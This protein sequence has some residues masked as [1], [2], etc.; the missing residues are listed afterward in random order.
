[1]SNLSDLLPAGA[2]AK[3][4]TATDSGSGITSGKPVILETA[5][6]VTQIAE[7][8]VSASIPEGSEST[9]YP[10]PASP[11]YT[12]AS[13]MDIAFDSNS[14]KFVITYA[15]GRNSSYFTYI[16]GEVNTGTGALTWGTRTVLNSFASSFMSVA[17]DPSTA[18]TLAVTYNVSGVFYVRVGTLS[19]TTLR[20]GTVASITSGNE[21]GQVAFD[22]TSGAFVVSYA[23]PAGSPA[24]SLYAI[25]GTYV[26]TTITLG[27][28]VQLYNLAIAAEYVAI[29][30]DPN[31]SGKFTTVTNASAAPYQGL[32]VC[33]TLS[34][35]TITEGT[36]QNYIATKATYPGVVYD[37]LTANRLIICF[38]DDDNS[39]Y[40]AAYAA[41][42]SGTVFTF[43]TK[44]QF[45]STAST[46][47]WPMAPAGVGGKFEVVYRNADTAQRPFTVALSLSGTTVTGGTPVQITTYGVNDR[48]Y[49][50]AAMNPNDAGS[51]V[52]SWRDRDYDACI[53][54]TSQ[55]GWVAT[56][57]TTSNFLGIADE[58]ISAS[59]SGVIVV[60]G[61]T[62]AK[63]TSLTIGSN[64]YV[65]NDGTITTVSST[66]SAGLAISTTSL[67]L[68]G[69]S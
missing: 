19:G 50:T 16:V 61:G 31:T 69:D 25:A 13:Y 23:D 51:F 11:P 65:Q 15:D 59:A 3:S 34:G 5:G 12:S 54:V 1:M 56:N 53:A 35:T 37:S 52:T 32:A 46:D 43:G 40:G 24:N 38:K 55:A 48:D 4:I 67:L 49:L 33:G 28:S 30:F 10:Q 18:G 22:F 27:S 62:S 26:G 29:A 2:S 6:T 14:N 42:L 17:F 66:V 41:T 58:A 45:N 57:L 44:L 20:F 21:Y 47:M 8:T 36:A 9:W 68:S 60:Q 63:L 7:T 39:L 64:Y